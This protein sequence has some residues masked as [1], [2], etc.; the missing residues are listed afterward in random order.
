VGFHLGL[1]SANTKSGPAITTVPQ[2]WSASWVD[3]LRLTRL[4]ED[5]G[6]DFMLPVARW[7]VSRTWADKEPSNHSGRL[8][9]LGRMNGMPKPY[10]ANRIPIINAVSSSQGRSFAARNA[11]RALIVVTGPAEGAKVVTGLRAEAATYGRDDG[12]FTVGHVVCRPSA[13]RP[14]TACATTRT[15]APTDRPSTRSCACV[16]CRTGPSH[17]NGWTLSDTGSPPAATPAHWP[18]IRT[19]WRTRSPR[20]PRPRTPPPAKQRPRNGETSAGPRLIG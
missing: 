19:T 5:V 12:V 2:R 15:N 13:P 16:A 17:Q 20:S 1:F 8:F 7:A 14:M 11:D 18:A 3:N 10:N 9:Q 4:A 6:I